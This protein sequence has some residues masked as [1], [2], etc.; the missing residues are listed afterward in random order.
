MATIAVG[1]ISEPEM[2]DGL[3][4]EEKADLIAF[5]RELLRHPYW[6]LHAAAAL[7][8][9]VAWPQQYERAKLA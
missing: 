9:R 7:G 1:L 5:G 8:Q 2:A 3:V 4:R 6:P